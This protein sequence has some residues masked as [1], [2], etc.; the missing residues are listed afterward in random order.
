MSFKNLK[1]D[2]KKS[3]AAMVEASS[4]LNESTFKDSDEGFWKLTVDKA[5][6]G[7]AIIRFLPPAEGDDVPWVQIFTHGFK[8]P[9]GWYIENCPTTLKKGCPACDH[10]STLWNSG[11]DANK[12]IASSQK[13]R[14]GYISNIY[15]VKDP[16]NKENEGKVF[17][18]RYGQKIFD[19]LN[20]AMHPEFDDETPVNPFDLWEGANF[21]LKARQVDGFRNYDKSTFDDS[22]PL[23]DDDNALEEVYNQEESIS[24]LIAPEEFKSEGELKGRLTKVLGLN[25]IGDTKQPVADAPDEKTAEHDL[26]ESTDSDSGDSDD[27]DEESYF[28]GLADED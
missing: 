12:K 16:G 20:D 15:V 1:K 22:A 18:Y 4:K 28:A 9:G 5:G 27:G 6:N 17:K 24:V 2:R 23:L 8:G 3:L 21:R 14:K 26:G 10:N 7:S 13:R 25:A 11:V 19:K